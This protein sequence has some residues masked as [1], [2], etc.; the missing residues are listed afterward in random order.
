MKT[1]TMLLSFII[2]SIMKE[3]I[4]LLLQCGHEHRCITL[5]ICQ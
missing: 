4:V 2:I 3:F 5:S 1:E